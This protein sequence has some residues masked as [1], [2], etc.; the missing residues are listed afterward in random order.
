VIEALV[1]NA[2]IVLNPQLPRLAAFEIY[3]EDGT[4]IWSKLALPDGMN[5]YPHCFP[6]NAQ[7]AHKLVEVLGLNSEVLDNYDPTDKT[8]WGISGWA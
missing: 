3:M 8:L 1:P 4:S 5:N 7:L 2:E 6:S